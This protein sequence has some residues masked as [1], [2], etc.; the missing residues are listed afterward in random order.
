MCKLVH[1]A[2]AGSAG[3]PKLC[4]QNGKVEE[5]QN[6]HCADE[7]GAD[8]DMFLGTETDYPGEHLDP[9]PT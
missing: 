3:L 6:S 9:M 4:F 8:L 2:L 5:K 1:N 7:V